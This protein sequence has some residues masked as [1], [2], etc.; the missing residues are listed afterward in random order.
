[1]VNL[2]WEDTRQAS[3]IPIVRNFPH[4]FSEELSGFPPDYEIKFVIELLPRNAPVSK[5][6]DYLAPLELKE[7]KIQL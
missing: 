1:M 5:V 4:V 6:S 2:S 7:L 3:D